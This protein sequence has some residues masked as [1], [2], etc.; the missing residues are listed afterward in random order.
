MLIDAR[1]PPHFWPWAVEHACFVNNRF[2]CL[3][4]KRVPIFDF[5]Q[6]LKQPHHDRVDFSCLPRFR[7]RAYKLIDS[8]PGKFEPRAEK[9]W[10]V[11]FPKN[12][13]KNYL[14]YHPRWAPKQGWKSIESCTPHITFN[15]DTI[16]GD[17]LNAT[18][19]YRTKSYL[20]SENPLPIEK[21]KP[22]NL[23]P[24]QCNQTPER[25]EG[26]I[27]TSLARQ[28]AEAFPLI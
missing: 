15:E 13:S 21:D 28:Q 24:S 11:G 9:W 3:R 23:P 14:I 7:Y 26:E 2:Y 5:L 12:T 16:F 18:D 4:T 8:K 6:G 19:R 1:M 10:F 25:F 17:M 20:A 22:S 27:L